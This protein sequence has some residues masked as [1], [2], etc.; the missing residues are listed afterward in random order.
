VGYSSDEIAAL[1]AKGAAGKRT[2][3]R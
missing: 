3:D 2:S 1:Q